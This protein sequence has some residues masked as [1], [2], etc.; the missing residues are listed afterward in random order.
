MTAAGVTADTTGPGAR[1]GPQL[2]QLRPARRQLQQ[3][4]GAVRAPHPV[5]DNNVASLSRG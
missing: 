1:R 5:R 3:F 2:V 4:D